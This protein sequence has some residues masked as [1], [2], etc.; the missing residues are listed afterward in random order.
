MIRVIALDAGPL[1]LIMQRKGI[2]TAD[3]CK[4]WL[5]KQIAAGTRILVPEIADFEVRRELVRLGHANAVARL[6]AFND[7][8]ADRYLPLTTGAIDW[9]PTFGPRRDSTASRP[10]TQRLWTPM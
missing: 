5:A 2:P 1:G 10:P 9:L 7:S 4:A 3:A 6:D 8:A